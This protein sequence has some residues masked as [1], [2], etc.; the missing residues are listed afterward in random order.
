MHEINPFLVFIIRVVEINNLGSP[1]A[2]LY[3]RSL[4]FTKKMIPFF[5]INSFLMINKNVI[6]II[7]ESLQVALFFNKRILFLHFGSTDFV[8][9]S[10]IIK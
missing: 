6:C 2:V 4:S 10:F 7:I 9:I 5:T 1:E 3:Y 8:K